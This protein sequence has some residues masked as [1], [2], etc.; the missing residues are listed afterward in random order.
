HRGTPTVV[1]NPDDARQRGVMD[2]DLIRV[3]NDVSEFYC[4]ARIGAGVRPG[5]II[6]YNG[7]EPLQYRGWSGANEIEPGMV[8]WSGFSGGYGHLNYA[9]LGWQPAPID[10]WVRCDFEKSLEAG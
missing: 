7:W 8:K 3:F 1:V 2:D 5:Q 9:F 6:S 4:R 10:R